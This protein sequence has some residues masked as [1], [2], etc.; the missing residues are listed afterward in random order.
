M[1]NTSLR[2]FAAVS[3]YDQVFLSFEDLVLWT[4]ALPVIRSVYK[5]MVPTET[6]QSVMLQ[7]FVH[8]M[9]VR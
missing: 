2:N 8:R 4:T 1:A 5:A 9:Q 3:T 6:G 7:S